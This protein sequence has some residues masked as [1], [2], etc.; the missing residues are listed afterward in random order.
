MI[1]P[2]SKGKGA[3]WTNDILSEHPTPDAWLAGAQRHDGSWWTD[4]TGWL[5]ARSGER[6]PAPPI[7]SDAHPPI[8]DAPGTYVLEK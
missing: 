8:V 6:I 4:L 7:G 3:Y 2:P 1:N 5:G